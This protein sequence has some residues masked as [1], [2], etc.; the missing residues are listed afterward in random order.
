[1][2]DRISVTESARLLIR[3]LSILFYLTIAQCILGYLTKDT[4]LSVVPWL[5]YPVYVSLVLCGIAMVV[6]LWMCAPACG[7]YQKAAIFMGIGVL[8]DAAAHFSNNTYVDA[9]IGYPAIVVSTFTLYLTYSAHAA[10]LHDRDSRLA[11][12]FRELWQY[13]LVT[14]VAMFLS[15]FLARASGVLALL[16]LLA[17]TAGNVLVTIVSI[18]SLRQ[19]LRILERDSMVR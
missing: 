11:A 19:M 1:M 15:P 17:A 14:V 6:C 18:V 8:M 12:R 16:V 10:I 5:S 2:K 3:W 13:T 9:M 7:R 4:V